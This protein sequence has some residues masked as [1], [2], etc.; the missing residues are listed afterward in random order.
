MSETK[1]AVLKPAT[2]VLVYSNNQATL[3]CRGHCARVHTHT[4]FPN[5]DFILTWCVVDW[6]IYYVFRWCQLHKLLENL[7]CGHFLGSSFSCGI[8]AVKGLLRREEEKGWCIKKSSWDS[9][10]IRLSQIVQR[11]DSSLIGELKIW[12]VVHTWNSSTLESKEGR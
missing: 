5:W 9:V 10:E 4:V 2:Y 8:L 7:Q 11:V 6:F 1:Y 12:V 3:P